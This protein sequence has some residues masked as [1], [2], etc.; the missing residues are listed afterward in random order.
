MRCNY[1]SSGCKAL[2]ASSRRSARTR[3]QGCVGPLGAARLG[4][5]GR[6]GVGGPGG[7]GSGVGWAGRG[8]ADRMGEVEGGQGGAGER[9]G[10]S[11]GGW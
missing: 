5:P 7:A 4:W 8:W 3:E 10:G 11:V 1:C 2:Q 9:G 6:M